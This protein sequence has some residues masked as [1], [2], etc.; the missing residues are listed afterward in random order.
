MPA[1]YSKKDLKMLAGIITIIIYPQNDP[2]DIL[3]S[4]L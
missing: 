2:M 1:I 3:A 4:L